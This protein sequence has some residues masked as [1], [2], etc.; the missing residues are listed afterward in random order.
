ML[1]F[2]QERYLSLEVLLTRLKK[3][4]FKI[5]F[6][7]STVLS[8]W[9]QEISMKFGSFKADKKKEWSYK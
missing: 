3:I 4:F 6:G 1:K 8:I 9:L 5:R 2:D 7:F